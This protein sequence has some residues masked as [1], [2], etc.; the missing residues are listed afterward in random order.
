M[1]VEKFSLPDFVRYML[2]G[3]NFI[4]LLVLLPLA[5]LNPSLLKEIMKAGTIFGVLLICVTFGFL[6][7][8]LKIYQISPFYKKRRDAL[9][10][11][12]AD[13]LEIQT[14]QASTYFSLISQLSR[15]DWSYNLAKRQS[16]W[17]LIVNTAIICGVAT[18]L[19]LGI[20]IYHFVSNA[21]TWEAAS[22]IGISLFF[23]LVSLR[24]FRLGA[25]ERDKSRREYLIFA[26]K[27]KKE[28]WDA[29]R[30]SS[31]SE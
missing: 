28:I 15:R 26:T 7:D 30:I 14:G 6:L 16:E 12:L 21:S 18:A 9:M 1:E 3:V 20:A 13:T 5:H 19:W 29:W 25:H 8:M 11:D 24:L 10:T 27:N 31:S 22:S 2:S 17:I 4:G 23:G